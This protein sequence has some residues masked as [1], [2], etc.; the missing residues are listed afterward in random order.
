MSSKLLVIVFILFNSPCSAATVTAE[1]AL[2]KYHQLTSL[3]IRD[4]GRGQASGDI[5]VCARGR[6][7]YLLPLPDQRDPR[8]HARRATGE[9]PSALGPGPVCPNR[10]CPGGGK[11]FD[12]IT[13]LGSAL[14]GR[15]E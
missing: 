4:C 3:E 12:A 10:G 5:V 1:E 13:K 11:L 6:S 7:K 9:I 2:A 14:L 8:D 15:D